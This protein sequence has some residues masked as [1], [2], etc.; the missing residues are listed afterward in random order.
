KEKKIGKPI[1][2]QGSGIVASKQRRARRTRLYPGSRPRAG[3]PGQVGGRSALDSETTQRAPFLP[4]VS[5]AEELREVL[6]G[7]LLAGLGRLA[8]LLANGL[9]LV[10]LVL[11]DRRHQSL[12]LVFRKLGVVHVLVPVLL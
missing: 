1:P 3:L 7:V 10:V 8:D 11:L 9:P 6:L 5:L 12:A 2:N 4:L